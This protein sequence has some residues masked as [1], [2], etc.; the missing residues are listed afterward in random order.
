MLF[1]LGHNLQQL[2]TRFDEAL[3][4]FVGD[5]VQVKRRADTGHYVFTLSVD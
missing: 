4:A 1:K 5:F 3:I 2:S